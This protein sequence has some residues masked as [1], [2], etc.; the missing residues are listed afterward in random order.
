MRKRASTQKPYLKLK[1]VRKGL[2]V[3]M[4]T[5]YYILHSSENKIR[6]FLSEGSKC[7]LKKSMAVLI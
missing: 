2:R 6:S 4:N 5:S 3:I 7:V 1:G